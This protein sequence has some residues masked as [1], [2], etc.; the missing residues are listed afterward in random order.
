MMI[1]LIALEHRLFQRGIE[2]RA[3]PTLHGMVAISSSS[4][5]A[6]QAWRGSAFCC[7]YI[8]QPCLLHRS[9]VLSSLLYS[10]IYPD[11]KKLSVI[12]NSNILPS[13][14]VDHTFKHPDS[15]RGFDHYPCLQ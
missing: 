8:F 4:F 9:I 15:S 3:Y 6:K 12:N 10:H 1:C 14:E 5:W 11:G 13:R 2:L 7:R